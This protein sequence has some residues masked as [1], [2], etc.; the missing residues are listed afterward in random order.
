MLKEF[1]R[2]INF[3]LGT[4]ISFLM[5]MLFAPVSTFLIMPVEYGKY[6]LFIV[7][8][9]LLVLLLGLGLQQSQIR[10]FHERDPRQIL[11]MNMLVTAGFF[12][13]LFPIM[14]V[15]HNKLN[16]FITEGS[17]VGWGVVVMLGFISLLTTI[18]TLGFNYLRMNH[19]ALKFSFIQIATQVVN[20]TLFFAYIYLVGANFHAFLSASLLS[21]MFQFCMIYF[22]HPKLGYIFSGFSWDKKLFRESLAF[23]L[24]FIPVF[25]IDY[26]FSYSDRYFL[27]FFGDLSTLGVYSIA[28]RFSYAF[29]ILQT[30][31]HTYW[32]PFSMQRFSQN[33]DERGF[34]K[35]I[36]QV[37]NFSLLLILLLVVLGKDLIALVIEEQF[38]G[39]IRYF[40]FLF[41]VPIYY[42]LS[43]VTF[44]GINFSKKT[45][46]HMIINLVTLGCNAFLAFL[47]IPRW[48]PAGAAMSCGLT[49]LCFFLL[50]S[51]FGN[52]MYPQNLPWRSFF[53]THGIMLAWVTADYVFGFDLIFRLVITGPIAGLLWIFYGGTVRRYVGKLFSATKMPPVTN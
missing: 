34:Y 6:A 7:A 25:A 1:K 51:Y 23:G 52:K 18:N 49:Y 27:R 11:G 45:S 13:L 12:A 17:F 29:T 20:Y 14:L 8:Q 35:D 24:P 44:V 39:V 9:N 30:G 33:P 53:I 16:F 19:E 32:V 46:L 22:I 10:F 48:G 41:F 38:Y 36:F 40:P 2:L 21:T 26:L 47:F 42:T 37:L 3:S 31:F 43:E 5:S 50:R 15:L 4:W 28:L